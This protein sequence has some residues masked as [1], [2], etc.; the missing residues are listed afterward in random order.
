VETFALSIENSTM[1]H[2]LLTTSVRKGLRASR[3]NW[4]LRQPIVCYL[5]I[6]GFCIIA[7]QLAVFPWK[8]HA[9]VL[10]ITMLFQYI[11]SFLYQSMPFTRWREQL[12]RSAIFLTI[13]ATYVP[14]WVAHSATIS[15][16]R[17][18]AVFCGGLFGIALILLKMPEFICGLAYAAYPSMG[19]IWSWTELTVWL[20]GIAWWIFWI[21]AFFYLLHFLVYATRSWWPV[22][23]RWIPEAIRHLFLIVATA[24][25]SYVALMYT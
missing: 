14:Y 7:F 1:M 21:G 18:L 8:W 9:A 12:D 4:S 2:R 16:Y 10:P 15:E 5:N 20:P 24:L 23:K 3:T 6:V 22:D 19:L 11:V 13:G 17:W 25:Q